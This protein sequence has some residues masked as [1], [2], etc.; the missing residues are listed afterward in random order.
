MPTA[1]HHT[2]N[3]SDDFRRR[4]EALYQPKG[5]VNVSRVC[6][7]NNRT[8]NSKELVEITALGTFI[9]DMDAKE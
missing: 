2:C 4:E 1:Q 7:V 9:I 8:C 3:W 6:V 5:L